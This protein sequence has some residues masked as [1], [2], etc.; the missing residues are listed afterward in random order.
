M[1]GKKGVVRIYE[2]RYNRAISGLDQ[3]ISRN[4]CGVGNGPDRN[5][6][7]Y[8]CC[9]RSSRSNSLCSSLSSRLSGN[10]GASSVGGS[11]L[12]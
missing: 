3:L 6:S 4:G 9:S 8:S 10:A 11:L 12:K 7:S 2:D 5:G 1:L